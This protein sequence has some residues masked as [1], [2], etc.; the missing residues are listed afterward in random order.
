[1]TSRPDRDAGAEPG[2]D[3]LDSA[4]PRFGVEAI[5]ALVAVPL[6]G[7]EPNHTRE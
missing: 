7:L 2:G 6:G 1:V 5:L 3:V 4:A